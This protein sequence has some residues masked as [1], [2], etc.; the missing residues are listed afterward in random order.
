MSILIIFPD[1]SLIPPLDHALIPAHSKKNQDY[2]QEHEQEQLQRYFSVRIL[3][4]Q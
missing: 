1:L 2:D 4:H 3:N